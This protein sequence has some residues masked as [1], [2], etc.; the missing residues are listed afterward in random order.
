VGFYGQGDSVDVH[1]ADG[2]GRPGV[3]SNLRPQPPTC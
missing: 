2:Q 3:A 1:Y